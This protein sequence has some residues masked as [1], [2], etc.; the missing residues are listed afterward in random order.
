[1]VHARK[2]PRDA[3]SEPVN[4]MEARETMGSAARRTL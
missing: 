3:R 1:M 2:H 4:G